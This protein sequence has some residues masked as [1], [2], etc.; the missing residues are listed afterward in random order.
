[1]TN[2]GTLSV[3]ANAFAS[4]N[5]QARTNLTGFTFETVAGATCDRRVANHLF[6]RT[7]RELLE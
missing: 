6:W 3:V 7:E 1:M 2:S 5:A 4:G